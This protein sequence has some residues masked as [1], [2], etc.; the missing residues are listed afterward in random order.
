MSQHQGPTGTE[1]NLL[2]FKQ[3]SGSCMYVNHMITE[4]GVL[5]AILSYNSL[6]GHHTFPLYPPHPP[7]HPNF[8]S[9]AVCVNLETE[10]PIIINFI[11]ASLRK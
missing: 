5:V 7:P 2:L 1:Y 8:P 10:T 11:Q 6:L 3:I 9:R 4:C